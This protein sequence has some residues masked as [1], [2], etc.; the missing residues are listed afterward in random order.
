MKRR[1]ER[2]SRTRIVRAPRLGRAARP[3]LLAACALA[4]SACQMPLVLQDPMAANG[5]SMWQSQGRFERAQ[6]APAET[7]EETADPYAIDVEPTPT[8]EERAPL[9]SWDG[10]VVDAP[11]LGTVDT[12]M[13][14]PARGLEPSV[15]GRMHIIEL[16]QT[17]LD[18]RD[19]LRDEVDALR[20]ALARSQD[21][22]ERARGSVAEMDTRVGALEEGNRV[23]AEENRELTSRLATA[24][25]R[26]LEAEKLL[27]ETQIAWHRER[28]GGDPV[29][30]RAGTAT[31]GV[32]G[33]P[34]GFELDGDR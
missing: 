22:F 6:T 30:A 28:A 27:L 14:P 13:E 7:F 8:P 19:M 1:P 33:Q 12:V 29:E 9:H 21:D 11:A 2:H 26:R 23:L 16:Y 4:A 25:V 18:E 31:T 34:A 20:A 3:A 5:F 17:V 32:T 15:E 10:G 24:Q